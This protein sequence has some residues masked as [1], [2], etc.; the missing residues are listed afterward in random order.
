MHAGPE[1]SGSSGG[2]SDM[3]ELWSRFSTAAKVGAFGGLVGYAVG[4]AAVFI[5]SPVA[6]II[7]TTLSS[8]LLVFCLWF[9]FGRELRNYRIQRTGLP[10]RATILDVRSTGIKINEFYPQI[11]LQLE[12]Q[13]ENGEPYQVKTKCLIDQVDIPVYQP[14]NVIDVTVD[15]KNPRKVAAGVDAGLP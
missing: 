2:F 8:L 10:A 14:G 7:I 15:R 5:A 6:G 12:V 11:E 4:M 9:F 3:R 1:R 13:P